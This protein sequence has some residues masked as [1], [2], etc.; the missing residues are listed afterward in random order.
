MKRIKHLNAIGQTVLLAGALLILGNGCG[1]KPQ[2][3]QSATAAGA[4]G[5]GGKSIAQKNCAGC[6]GLDGKGANDDIPHLA[7][8]YAD[9]LIQSL[10][11]YKQGKRTHAALKD[12]A[13]GMSDAQIQSVANYYASLPPISSGK[14]E[15]TM[16]SPY[17]KGKQ[18]AAACAGCHAEDGNST[19]AGIPNLAGQQPIY[20]ISAVNDYL[21]GKRQIATPQKEAMVSALSRVDIEAMALYYASQSPVKRDAPASGDPAKGEPLSA[22]CGGCHG[23]HGV[24]H[25]SAVPSL[26]SQDPEYV[27]KATKEYRNRVREQENMHKVVTDIN[28]QQ[29]ADIAAF[30]A[31]QQGQPA[32]QEPVSIQELTDQC[33]R[34]HAPSM[35]AT[36]GVIFPKI[37]GQ[38]KAYLLKALREYRDG[39]RESSTMHKMSLPYSDAIIESLATVY[40]NRP[41]E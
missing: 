13:L 32:Q 6:H 8:Q 16:I 24:S 3:K 11:A 4:D 10:N 14:V 39:V 26:A 20:F 34:C 25:D 22:N 28:D 9:Y 2:D 27:V 41:A 30:Y 18:T 23:S 31:V 15:D 12:M 40:A 21:E 19:Q 37:N 35:E 38:H 7:A 1:E 36:P 5:A 29:L 17:E 33:D